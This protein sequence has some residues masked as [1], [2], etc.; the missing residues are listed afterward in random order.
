[1]HCNIVHDIYNFNGATVCAAKRRTRST[2]SHA[3][4]SVRN[5]LNMISCT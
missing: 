4:R 5:Q 2:I 3:G 1:M